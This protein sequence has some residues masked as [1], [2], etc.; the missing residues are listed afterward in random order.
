MVVVVFFGEINQQQ[1]GSRAGDEDSTLTRHRGADIEE[2]DH[3]RA[4]GSLS[5]GATVIAEESE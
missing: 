3:L 2:Q 4:F 1:S 5:A